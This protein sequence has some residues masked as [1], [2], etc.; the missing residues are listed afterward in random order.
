MLHVP[1]QGFLAHW[2]FATESAVARICRE[3]GWRMATNPMIRDLDLVAPKPGD[4]RRIEV[5]GV[6]GIFGS[7]FLAVDATMV[8]P[9]RADG[10][11]RTDTDRQRKQWTFS[12]VV[13]APPLSS[14]SGHRNWYTMVVGNLWFLA[15]QSLHSFAAPSPRNCRQLD[16]CLCCETPAGSIWREQMSVVHA[17]TELVSTSSDDEDSPG[18]VGR[19]SRR[20]RSST[21][22]SPQVGAH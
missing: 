19:L 13:R 17:S 14:P 21:L 16:G 2:G 8:S 11:L 9:V 22:R 3:G 20:Y 18:L 5:S 1:V 4:L 7:V 6:L 10:M 15:D 12:S